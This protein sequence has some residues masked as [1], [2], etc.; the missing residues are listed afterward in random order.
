MKFKIPK[1]SNTPFPD[2]LRKIRKAKNILQIEMAG[3]IELSKSQYRNYEYGASEPSLANL[4]RISKV[5]NCSVDE[6]LKEN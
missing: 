1:Y 3:K 6:L 4:V 2:N 5:L